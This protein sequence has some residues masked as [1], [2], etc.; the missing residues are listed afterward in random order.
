VTDF[1]SIKDHPSESGQSFPLGSTL[2]LDGANFSLFCKNGTSVELLLFNHIDDIEPAKVITLDAKRNKTYHYW[3]A[4]VP[5]IA[6][7]QLY[8]YRVH[9]PFEPWNGHRYD[10]TKVLL[11]PYA[12]VVAVPESYRRSGAD[13]LY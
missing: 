10:A 1:N 13:F 3:H 11:D 6:E 7:G 9:G 12:K 4:F 2:F 5:N 8:A